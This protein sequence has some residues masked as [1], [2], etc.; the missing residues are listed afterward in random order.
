MQIQIQYI[1][2]MD[3]LIWNKT[4]VLLWFFAASL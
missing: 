1:K 4:V 2:L 3:H